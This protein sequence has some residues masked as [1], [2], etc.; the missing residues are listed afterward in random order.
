MEN[1]PLIDHEL[2]MEILIPKVLGGYTEDPKPSVMLDNDGYFAMQGEGDVRLSR[3]LDR[4]EL[5]RLKRAIK[6]VLKQL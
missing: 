4:K 2:K 3:M 6:R 1:N 5:K